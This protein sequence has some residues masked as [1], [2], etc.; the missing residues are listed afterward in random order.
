MK[1]RI[2]ELERRNEQLSEK[3]IGILAQRR[4]ED[5]ESLG[6]IARLESELAVVKDRLEDCEGARDAVF[7]AMAKANEAK[8]LVEDVLNKVE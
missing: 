1:A 4:Q 8:A 2:T 7:V 5:A 3:L 6:R